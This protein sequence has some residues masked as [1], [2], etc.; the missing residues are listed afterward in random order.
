MTTGGVQYRAP[1]KKRHNFVVAPM[2][3]LGKW[4]VGLVAAV[5]ALAVSL[6]TVVPGDSLAAAL[7]GVPLIVL[8]PAAGVALYAAIFRRGD[9]ALS[10]YAAA[11][12]LV[13]GILFVVLHPLFISD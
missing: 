9:R 1:G 5:F 6:A 4:A 10:V 12:L 8:T 3:R 11:F 13:A 7:V 2:T